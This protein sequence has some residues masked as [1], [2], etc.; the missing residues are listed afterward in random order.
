[1][2]DLVHAGWSEGA[3]FLALPRVKSKGQIHKQSC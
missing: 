1:M 3:A 2:Q